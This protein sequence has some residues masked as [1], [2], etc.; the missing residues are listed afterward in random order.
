MRVPRVVRY[1][2]NAIPVFLCYP[3][4]KSIHHIETGLFQVWP[5]YY[6]CEQWNPRF[7]RLQI[8]PLAV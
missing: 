1:A 5:R 6:R 8:H 3:V 7:P 2:I 4:D